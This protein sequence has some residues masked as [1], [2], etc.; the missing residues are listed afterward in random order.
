MK[1]PSNRNKNQEKIGY[2]AS[3]IKTAVITGGS[4]GL[5]LAMAKRFKAANWQ[6]VIVSRKERENLPCDRFYS[7]DLTAAASTDKLIPQLLADGI[8]PDVWINNAGIGVYALSEELTDADLRKIMELNYFA[9]VNL[10]M[11]ILPVLKENNGSLVQICSIASLM[12]LCCMSTYSS[13]KSA[14]LMFNESLRMET[15]VHVL[16]VMPGR[17]NTGFSSRAVKLREC[18]DTPGNNSSSPDKL[19]DKV[20]KAVM[21]RKKTLI[22]PAWY[23]FVVLTAKLF[24]ALTRRVSRKI[25][26]LDK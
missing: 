20:F 1:N 24:P 4:S 2:M 25:W 7:C 26:E 11:K 17:I 19:A 21:K 15:D 6:V 16:S 22:Y 12:P 13:S 9:P 18:P 5:G 3:E 23:R 10:S 8:R 14:L